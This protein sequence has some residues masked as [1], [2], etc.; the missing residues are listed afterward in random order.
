MVM[1]L[2]IDFDHPLGEEERLDAQLAI[3]A[4]AKSKKMHH[5][6]GDYG[7][8]VLGEAMSIERVREALAEMNLNPRRIESTLD[9]AENA[10]ADDLE[11]TSAKERVRAIGR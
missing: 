4:L 6:R 8:T 7:I 10:E 2:E 9:D 11:T 5:V 1:R 3:A